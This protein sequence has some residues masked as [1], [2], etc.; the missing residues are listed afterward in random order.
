MDLRDLLLAEELSEEQVRELLAPFELRDPVAVD[1][2]L[3]RMCA[4]PADR[5]ALAENLQTYLELAAR[6]PDALMCLLQVDRIAEASGNRA[7]VYRTLG[8]DPQWLDNVC[9][10][11]ANSHALA[12]VLVLNPEYLNILA[13]ADDLA[14]TRTLDDLRLEA[15]RLTSVFDEKEPALNALRRMRRRE[16]LR[17]GARELTGLGSFE[18]VVGEISDLARAL[19]GESLAVCHEHVPYP[20]DKAKPGRLAVIAFGKLGA[21]ELN[22]SS[23]IDIALVWDSSEPEEEEQVHKFYM[24]LCQSLVDG[25]G[26]LSAEGR[27]YR[28]DLRLRPFGKSGPIGMPL[29]QFMNYYESYSEPWE[30]QALIKARAI[31]GPPDLQERINSFIS[32]FTFSRPMDPV[33]IAS[34]V[35]VKDRSESFRSGMAAMDRQV[36]HGWGGIRDVEFA[37]Q[38]LQLIGG[39]REPQVRTPATLDALRELRN[40]GLL[41]GREEAVLASAYVFLRQVEHRLQLV[42]ELPRQVLPE[43]EASLRHLAWSMGYRDEVEETAQGL[44]LK[45]YESQ[46]HAVRAIHERLFR[47]VTGYTEETA[48]YLRLLEG[49]DFDVAGEA[50]GALRAFHD[51]AEA[52]RRLRQLAGTD[53][54]AGITTEPQRRFLQMLPDLLGAL[55]RSPDPD[56]SLEGLQRVAEATGS[57][58]SFFRA[59][60]SNPKALAV[61]I[62]LAASSE[63][64]TNALVRHPEYIDRVTRPE[65][66]AEARTLGVLERELAG[67]ME[68]ESSE[69]GRLNALRRYRLREFL[70][71]GI[72]DVAGLTRVTA[73]TREISLLAEA[74]IRAAYLL[75]SGRLDGEHRLPGKLSILGMGKLGGRELHYSSDVDLVCVYENAGD[76]SDGHRAFEKAVRGILDALG[77]LTAEGRGFSVDLR[78]RPEGKG[79]MLALPLVGYRRYLDDNAQ[80]WERLALVRARYVAGDRGLARRLEE[81]ME[82]CVWGRDVTLEDLENLR[83]I[84]RRIE[85]EKTR[86]SEELVD[87]KLGRGGIL[88]IEFTVQMLQLLYGAVHPALRVQNTARAIQ[89]IADSRLLGA[90]EA[91]VLKGA[92]L[93]LRRAENRLQLLHERSAEGV[94][95]DEV[96]TF[97]RRL[98]YPQRQQESA[99]EAFLEDLKMH[100]QAVWRIHESVYFERDMVRGPW[101]A[102]RKA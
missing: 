85:K 45:D 71:I 21:G 61:F 65:T 100:T 13:R 51:P 48:A 5:M 19:V 56:A 37:A 4:D 63:F 6:S 69:E 96:G 68:N 31:A 78:L 81:L 60:T 29:A 99:G 3:Q 35:S 87:L 36:K 54:S 1:A 41:S 25:I 98:G 94:R 46:T 67:R 80:A 11:V 8:V 66:L 83:H 74:C 14:R 33:S 24:R 10:V 15:S 49:E 95:L 40:V 101:E 50:A 17:I 55:Q 93:F 52:L 58:L 44:F 26:S 47:E 82:K 12:D 7:A 43:D 72:R 73:T 77:K 53:G 97:A 23:D 86:S 30:R 9:T 34:I 38:M 27:M 102:P 22:Y 62:R 91:A 59:L 92:Y 57:A 2:S 28:V 89:A 70:R 84:K 64:L 75:A 88:D 76:V 32:E 39:A 90:R 16:Y 18:E 42:E 20:D 79:G